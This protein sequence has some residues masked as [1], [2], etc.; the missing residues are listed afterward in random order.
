MEDEEIE[1]WIVRFWKRKHTIHWLD[2]IYDIIKSVKKEIC[3]RNLIT[4]KSERKYL[5]YTES[6]MKNRR[7]IIMKEKK[8]KKHIEDKKEKNK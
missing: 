2:V 7:I 3:N 5:R 6:E 4:K 1:Q 8:K